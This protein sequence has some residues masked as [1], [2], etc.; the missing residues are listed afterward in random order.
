M[1]TKKRKKIKRGQRYRDRQTR[2]MV[3]KK[4]V[5][6]ERGGFAN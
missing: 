2:E 1:V 4:E 3:K 5:D 6:D